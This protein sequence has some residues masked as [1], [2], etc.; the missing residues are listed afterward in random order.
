M[1]LTA[2]IASFDSVIAIFAAIIVV[3]L[4]LISWKEVQ[5]NT[6]WGVL[7]LFGGGITLFAVLKDSGASHLYGKRY[8]T[9]DRRPALLR[10]RP[11]SFILHRILNRVHL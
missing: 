1:G 7:M 2:K 6:D 3:A 9:P 10:H 4:K 11:V 8:R 5:A